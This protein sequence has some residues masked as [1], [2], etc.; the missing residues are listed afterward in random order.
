MVR[1]G[2]EQSVL[3]FYAKNRGASSWAMILAVHGEPSPPVRNIYRQA[4]RRLLKKQMLEPCGFESG[5]QTYRISKRV[6][7][8]GLTPTRRG[9]YA[10]N[11]HGRV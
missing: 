11:D 1:L 5:F 8:R 6:L 4:I 10:V 2:I 9:S 7:E 3:A